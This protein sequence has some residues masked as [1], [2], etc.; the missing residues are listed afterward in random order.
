MT[1]TSQKLVLTIPASEMAAFLEVLK[2]YDFVKVD[3][4]DDIIARFMKNAP[5]NAPVSEEEVADILM[6]MR[7][8]K[9]PTSTK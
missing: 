4:F 2:S 3:Q 9:S 7:Y 1:A 5:K 6:E 8:E